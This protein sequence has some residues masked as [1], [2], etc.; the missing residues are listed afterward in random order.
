VSDATRK[1][2]KK[3]SHQAKLGVY[4]LADAMSS[5]RMA[6]PVESCFGGLAIYR[7]ELFGGCSYSHRYDVPPFMLDCEHVVLHKCMGDK[8]RAKIVSNPNM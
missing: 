6:V 7:T 1:A 8:H 4:A 2:L 3:A 5:Q